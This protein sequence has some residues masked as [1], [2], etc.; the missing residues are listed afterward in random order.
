MLT[1]TQIAGIVGA[2]LAGAAYVPQISHLIRERPRLPN[3]GMVP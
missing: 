2:G 1:T 3:L